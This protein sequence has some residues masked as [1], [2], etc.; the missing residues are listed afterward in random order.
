MGH[1]H[2]HLV[3]A[4]STLL[5]ILGHLRFKPPDKACPED[6]LIGS[7]PG[8]FQILDSPKVRYQ[9]HGHQ[10]GIGLAALC[11]EWRG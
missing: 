5:D 10:R 6:V 7:T 4:P 8:C 1:P 9:Q 11:T 2:A 3:V